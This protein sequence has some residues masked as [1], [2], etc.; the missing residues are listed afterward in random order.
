MPKGERHKIGEVNHHTLRRS[1]DTP[2]PVDEFL[3]RLF[4]GNVRTIWAESFEEAIQKY[5]E[6]IQTHGKYWRGPKGSRSK[7][8]LRSLLASSLKEG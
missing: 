7:K 6:T 4:G 1:G 3:P 5:E 8:R 2:Y